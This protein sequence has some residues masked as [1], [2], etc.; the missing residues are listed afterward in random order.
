MEM[1]RS[2]VEVGKAGDW[3]EAAYYKRRV[4]ITPLLTNTQNILYL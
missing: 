1:D 2:D 4:T 3:K